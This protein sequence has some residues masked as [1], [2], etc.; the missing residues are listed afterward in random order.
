MKNRPLVSVTAYP[1]FH[2]GSPVHACA[3]A[4]NNRQLRRVIPAAASRP[5]CGC[6]SVLD[7]AGGLWIELRRW[8]MKRKPALHGLEP[9]PYKKVEI[10]PGRNNAQLAGA[11][12]EERRRVVVRFQAHD[13]IAAM[14]AGV[15]I[16]G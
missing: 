4:Q 1:I 3:L 15:V 9:V 12:G 8:A 10:D 11:E 13:D 14:Q 5:C 2:F 6:P 16:Q 7:I